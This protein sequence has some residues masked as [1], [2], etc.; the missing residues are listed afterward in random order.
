MN[1]ITNLQSTPTGYGP[2]RGDTQPWRAT[3]AP[4]ASASA[5]AQAAALATAS[6]D[7]V[8]ISP[9]ARA[10]MAQEEASLTDAQRQALYREEFAQG[11]P[12]GDIQAGLYNF[13][14]YPSRGYLQATGWLAT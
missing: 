14:K 5:Q 3:A 6:T 1:T 4:S 13:T 11:T 2:G 9:A 8:T 12:A 7:R 10:L